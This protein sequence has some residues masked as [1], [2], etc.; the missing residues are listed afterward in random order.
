MKIGRSIGIGVSVLVVLI[1]AAVI[2]V[3]SSLDAIVAGTI[4]KY[5]TQVTQTPV[6][7]SSVS[8][9]LA[10]GAG[11]IEQ[12]TVG[13]PDGFSA[14][15]I[16]SLGGISTRLD[17]AS[18]RN[19]PVVIEE[20]NISSPVVYYEIDRDGASNIKALQKNIE[21]STGG[22]GG[23]RSAEA[24]ESG[25]P[26]V[27]IRK[28]VID[29]GR[30]NASV[31]VLGDKPRSTDLPRI[32]MN[33]IGEKSGGATGAEVAG[34][35]IKAIIARVGPAVAELGLEKYLGKN[36]DEAKDLL[37]ERAGQELGTRVKEGAGGLKNLLNR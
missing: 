21:Q 7:V 6:R 1:I 3:F 11:S 18:V 10:S 35:V 14:P 15:E 27:L 29:G 19:D 24:K 9:D 17:V 2:Y 13:N 36:L 16:I 4:Q 12:L 37:D 33:N 5:G 28:L 22:G 20:I 32:Q 8:I 25:G 30:I 26:K 31:A 34:Q 23:G